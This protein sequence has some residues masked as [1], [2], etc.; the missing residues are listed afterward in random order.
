MNIDC[1]RNSI[2]RVYDRHFCY[3][4][5][6]FYYSPRH[7][8]ND[9]GLIVGGNV[10]LIINDPTFVASATGLDNGSRYNPN[11]VFSFFVHID[12]PLIGI[13]DDVFIVKV[14]SGARCIDTRLFCLTLASPAN[15]C[16]LSLIR[17]KL[18]VLMR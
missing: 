7:V 3:V 11:V 18:P 1:I 5:V 8:T 14:S 2:E 4:T 10:T 17:G 13:N 15:T 9:A 16:P 12:S 6:L